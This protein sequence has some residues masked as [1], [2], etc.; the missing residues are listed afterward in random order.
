M[1]LLL[2]THIITTSDLSIIIISN[3]NNSN[4]SKDEGCE[5]IKGMVLATV[6]TVV[7]G[8]SRGRE[9]VLQ[10]MGDT[11]IILNTID[12]TGGRDLPLIVD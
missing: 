10:F 1:S 12:A 7:E 4:S 2:H 9:Q 8:C 3:S 5:M 6:R 11:L